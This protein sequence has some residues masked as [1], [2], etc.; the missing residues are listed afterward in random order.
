M[1][2]ETR[3]LSSLPLETNHSSSLARTR[4]TGCSLCISALKLQPRDNKDCKGD[5]CS[6][7]CCVRLHAQLRSN[8]AEANHGYQGDRQNLLVRKS[9]SS[10]SELCWCGQ[11]DAAVLSARSAALMEWM[12]AA[13]RGRAGVV[14]WGVK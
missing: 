5:V 2:T 10:L 7:V 9:E 13:P 1:D 12:T 14:S 8:A 11:G 6:E 4:C 3:L